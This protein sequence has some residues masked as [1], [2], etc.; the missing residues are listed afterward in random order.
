MPEKQAVPDDHPLKK[1][2]L[3]YVSSDAGANS[4]KWA[5]TL[6]PATQDDGS[7]T[8]A[9]NYYRGSMWAAFCAGWKAA[10]ETQPETTT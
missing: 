8:V 7:V 10:Q 2:W 9:A 3:E 5:G 4:I 1:A 6:T